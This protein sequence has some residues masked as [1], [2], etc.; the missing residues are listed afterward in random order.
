[1]YGTVYLITNNVNG[2][3]YV[4]QTTV[5]VSQRWRSHKKAVGHVDTR[6]YRAINKYG[7]SNFT[8]TDIANAGD[9]KSLDAAENYFITMYESCDRARG[10]NLREGGFHG[11]FSEEARQKMSAWQK[12]R[13]LTP[14]HRENISKGNAGANNAFYGKKHTPESLDKMRGRKRSEETKQKLSFARRGKGAAKYRHDVSTDLL[15]WLYMS[16]IGSH[17]IAKLV[18]MDSAA[19]WARLKKEGVIRGRQLVE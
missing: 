16:G 3:I 14:E 10:Y 8:V 11:R 7:D 2:K 18:K 17:T 13:K 1:M 6:L 15:V 12:G 9:R 5:E 19:V 4:G